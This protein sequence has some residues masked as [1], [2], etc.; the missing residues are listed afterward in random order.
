MKSKKTTKWRLIGDPALR[1]K[2]AFWWRCAVYAFTC[3]GVAAVAAVTLMI[4][5][6]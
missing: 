3:I 5:A 4:C 2:I 1:E 6:W